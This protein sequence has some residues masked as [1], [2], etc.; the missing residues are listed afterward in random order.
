VQIIDVF[1]LQ[2]CRVL[3]AAQ[4]GPTATV[5]RRLIAAFWR[6]PQRAVRPD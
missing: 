1:A 6:W 4:G 3:L 5:F 2:Q